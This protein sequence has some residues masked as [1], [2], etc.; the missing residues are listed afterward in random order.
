MRRLRDSARFVGWV[1]SAFMSVKWEQVTGKPKE[2]VEAARRLH[3]HIPCDSEDGEK[4]LLP[5][6]ER[7][8]GES[9]L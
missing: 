5:E 2:L 6:W 7:P 8:T 1:R 9:H 4:L 3:E